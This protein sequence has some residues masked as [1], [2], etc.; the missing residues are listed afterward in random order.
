MTE[1]KLPLSGWLIA[2]DID[3]TLNDKKRRLPKRNFDA[4]QKFVYEYGGTFILSSG[5]SIES[6]RNHF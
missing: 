6:M 2:S 5:R 3:G 4:I 1:K